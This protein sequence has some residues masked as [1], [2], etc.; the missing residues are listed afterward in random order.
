RSS[1]MAP[2]RLVLLSRR[3]LMSCG[4]GARESGSRGGCPLGI[5]VSGPRSDGISSGL[6]QPRLPHFLKSRTGLASLKPDLQGR[7]T[8][9]QPGMSLSIADHLGQVQIGDGKAAADHMAVAGNVVVKHLE[10]AQQAFG[11]LGNRLLGLGWP[12]RAFAEVGQNRQC[13]FFDRGGG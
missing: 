5:V 1:A 13:V 8:A 7:E 3:Y 11:S 4:P 12:W 2:A 6:I 10:R 9:H